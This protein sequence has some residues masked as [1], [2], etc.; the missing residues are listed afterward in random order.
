[1]ASGS[2]VD[3]TTLYVEISV[4][5]KSGAEVSDIMTPAN[6][7]GLAIEVTNGSQVA[8]D[9]TV[10]TQIPSAAQHLTF[11][12][13]SAQHEW[14]EQFIRLGWNSPIGSRRNLDAQKATAD[15]R[16]QVVK[17]DYKD[18]GSQ[19]SL[20]TWVPSNPPEVKIKLKQ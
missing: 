19:A 14:R 10:T 5:D 11:I 3:N 1:V 6:S 18:T 15:E 4:R 8:K 16:I 7:C 17:V 13:A 2:Y 9:A 12:A 20:K